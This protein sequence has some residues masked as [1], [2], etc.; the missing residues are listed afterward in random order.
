MQQEIFFFG[1]GKADG[2]GGMKDVLGGKGAG[3]AEMTNAGVPV[4]PGFTIS[5]R[6]CIAYQKEGRVQ[7]AVQ[8]EQ[9]RY[10]ERLEKL[11][12]KKLG[13]PADPLLVSVRSGAK[14]SMPGMMD[15]ILN[16]G[17]ND[18][19]V[20]GLTAKT[21]NERFAWDCYRRFISMFSD[22]VLD[23]SKRR[24]EEEL[25]ALKK[26]R[27]V[28]LD[29]DLGTE[30]LKLLVARFRAIIKEAS[31]KDFPQDPRAQLDMARDAVFRSWNNPRATYYRRQNKIPD[32]LGTAVNVQAMVFGNMGPSSATGVGFTRN[33]ASGV[34]EFYGEYLTNA[35]GEDV[36]AGIRTPKPIVELGKEMPAAYKQL[37]E[38]TDHLEKHYKDIQDFEFTIEDGTLYLLQTRTGKR[39]GAA[40]VKIAV[41]MVHEGLIDKKTA[42]LRVPPGDLDQLL[43]P[44]VNPAKKP[45]VLAQGLP[46][47]PGAASGRAVFLA[48]DAL[49]WSEK[50]E[51]VVLIRAETNPDDIHGMDAARGILTA[52]GGMTSH[53]AVVARGMG[54]PCVAGCGAAEVSEKERVFRVGDVTVKEG[55]WVTIDGTTGELM[56]GQAELMEP[57]VGGEFAE[58]MSWADSFRRLKVRANADVPRDAKKAIEMGAEGIGLCRTEHM[59]FGEDRI[60]WVREM[61]L[62][63]GEYRATQAEL[64]AARAACEKAGG[65][66]KAD[67][68]A[69]LRDAEQKATAPAKGYLGALDMLLPMQKSDFYG[70]LKAMAGKPVTIRT[71]DPPLHEFLPKREELMVEIAVMEAKGQ[72]GAEL[73]EK[74]LLL[75]RV[76]ILHEFNPMLGHRGCRLGITF[77]EITA[78][79]VRAIIEA[80]CDLKKEGVEVL[81]EIMIPLV[82][83]KTELDNQRE[84]V[85]RVA[86]ETLGRM[87]VKLDYL[88]GT[89]IEVPR[90]ALT[91]NEIAETAQFFSFGTND[92]TQMTL[93][94]SRDDVGRFLPYYLANGL[95]KQDPFISLDRTGVGDLVRIAV[96]RGRSTNPKIKI[97]ICGEHGGD[98]DSVFFCHG[99][100]FD[101][102]SCSPYRVPI[103]RLAAAHAA[104]SEGT[105]TAIGTTA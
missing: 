21:G 19:S 53:A 16:L 9:D 26:E 105:E 42:V 70:V 12:G 65:H 71:L 76:E 58:F 10:I 48:D 89:M 3:L 40:A 78:M 54:K 5:T 95:L 92:L 37:R 8:T 81:P 29:L 31:G 93:G 35:Q 77:P 60:R 97:G 14:F 90:A 13:D 91:A 43:H 36:V 33:P 101:Y 23:I 15:T 51:K 4:P 94:F 100:G 102:V 18:K 86:T 1:G 44:R 34:K 88:V 22:V 28:K 72:K 25:S 32:D 41:D 6:V 63:A 74:K 80:A 30:D 56:L 103:A 85:V 50:G 84:V 68:E 104:L 49:A 55:D 45:K 24:F 79:Q 27:G 20:Q 64:A 73:E 75:R 67:A 47:S 87:G 62:S 17:L 82:G 39:T 69:R 11:L 99:L 46:A 38:I 52:T 66:D 2:N 83:N 61:I 98:P 57:T 7:A 96:E 59:F